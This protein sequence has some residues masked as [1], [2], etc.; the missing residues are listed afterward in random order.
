MHG[1][2]LCNY[3][4]IA[5]LHVAYTCIQ[6]NLSNADAIGTTHVCSEYEGAHISGASG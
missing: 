3:S 4:Q 5:Q 1:A 6:W 2:L